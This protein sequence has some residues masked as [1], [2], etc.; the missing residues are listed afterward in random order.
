MAQYRP[1]PSGG[2]A[3][4]GT[5]AVMRMAG[6]S[7]VH[8]TPVLNQG[9]RPASFAPARRL[10]TYASTLAQT[11]RETIALQPPQHTTGPACRWGAPRFEGISPS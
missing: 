10:G 6:V 2:V 4:S 5:L 9:Q 11:H 1:S 7:T 3:M 8:G